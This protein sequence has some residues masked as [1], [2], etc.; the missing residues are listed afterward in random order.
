[1]GENV[2][3]VTVDAADQPLLLTV[4]VA[5]PLCPANTW[6][7]CTPKLATARLLDATWVW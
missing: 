7:G 1:V 4:T 3:T 6:P 5:V 2:V